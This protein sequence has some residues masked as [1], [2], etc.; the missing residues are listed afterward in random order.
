MKTIQ[1]Y[2]INEIK[3]LIDL[4][5][6]NTNFDLKFTVTSKNSRPFKAIVVDQVSLDSNDIPEYKVATDGML[7]GN[8]KS[9]S[10]VYVNYYLIL[11]ADEEIEVDV[12]T[13]LV[14]LP[15]NNNNTNNNVQPENQIVNPIQES[16]K[17]S[18]LNRKFFGISLKFILIFVIVLIG[19][20]FVYYKFFYN[21]DN[22]DN[23][24]DAGLDKESSTSEVNI[25]IE[26]ALKDT[27]NS[28]IDASKDITNNIIDANVEIDTNNIVETKPVESVY[29]NIE[30]SEIH[31]TPSIQSESVSV[32]YPKSY[33]SSSNNFKNSILSRIENL[34][35]I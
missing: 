23:L 20:G 8:V 14:P 11:K 32:N 6:N 3:K 9:D 15:I 16:E 10:G 5:N 34:P 21:S 1:S 18:F 4:N 33:D 28:L 22:S 7:N 26:D 29:S 17:T 30:P 13:D 25:S 24:D 31:N 12:E 27:D 19:A 2:K 35:N